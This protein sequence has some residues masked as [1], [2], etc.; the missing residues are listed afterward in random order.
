MKRVRYHPQARVEFLQQVEYFAAISPRLAEHFD[1]AV[2]AAEA[3]AARTPDA[4]PRSM[5]GTRRVI[6]RRF[7]F[8]L[9]YVERDHDDGGDVLIIALAPT[10]R[11]P[12]YWRARLIDK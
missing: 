10:K 2:R 4:W 9:V 7:K 3:H 8:S 1:A 6:D 12:G 5:H 11:R